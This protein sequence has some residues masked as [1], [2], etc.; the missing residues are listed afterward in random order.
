MAML[1]SSRIWMVS[2][3]RSKSLVWYVRP[4]ASSRTSP[5]PTL[6]A[7]LPKSPSGP[8]GS[9]VPPHLQD[10]VLEPV[11]GVGYVRQRHARLFRGAVVLAPVSPAARDHHFGPDILAA[12]RDQHEVVA[13][14][15]LMVDR[16]A[17][18][19]TQ[20]T[21]TLEQLEV[22][23]SAQR[24]LGISGAAPSPAGLRRHTYPLPDSF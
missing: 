9:S 11:G 16:R 1:P 24:G 15:A 12:S 6:A 7:F 19:R 13:S 18:V 20:V 5:D 2:I 8:T 23:V 14:Q 21:I 17:A 4:L 10:E 22:G 3:C